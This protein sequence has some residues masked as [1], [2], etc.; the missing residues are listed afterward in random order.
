MNSTK[1]ISNESPMIVLPSLAARIGLNEAIMLQQ[2]NYWIGIFESNGE[3]YEKTHLHNKKFWIYN[4]YEDWGKQFP[5][6]SIS[7]IR[8][9]LANLEEMGLIETSNFNKF[10]GDKTKWY[11][12]N[13][14][15]IEELQTNKVNS[16]TEENCCHFDNSAYSYC[17]EE[18][19]NLSK[20]PDQ[21]EQ[22]NTII[23]PQENSTDT[24]SNTFSSPM[25]EEEKVAEK[26]NYTVPVNIVSAYKEKLCENKTVSSS[27]KKIL[28]QWLRVFNDSIIIKAIEYA[29]LHSK[30]K[31]ISYLNALLEDWNKKGLYECVQ[32]DIYLNNRN[33]IKE[34]NKVIHKPYSAFCDFEQ[35]IYNFNEL[36][37]KLLTLSMG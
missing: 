4:T 19:S 24:S 16:Q 36:E 21:H 7:T 35:R 3:K 8:R 33:S 31:N 17:T 27:E 29:A 5:F 9:T 23:V 6:W 20:D 10:K 26:I 30:S 25:E 28:K 13:Q 32:V 18:L 14:K 2:I 37:N 34:V 11:S 1:T 12:I 15:K 22:S